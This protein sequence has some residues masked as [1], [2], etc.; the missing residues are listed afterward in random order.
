MQADG[1]PA[2]AASAVVA[3]PHGP[4]R[5]PVKKQ[6]RKLGLAIATLEVDDMFARGDWAVYES[7][8]PHQLLVLKVQCGSLTPVGAEPGSV[9]TIVSEKELTFLHDV[10]SG[11]MGNGTVL[12]STSH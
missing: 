9:A 7:V 6:K 10:T 5:P 4:V 2:V 1:V 12:L 8:R 11:V 3:K